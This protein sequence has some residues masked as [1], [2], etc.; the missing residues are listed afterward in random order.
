MFTA[1]FHKNQFLMLNFHN[2][3]TNANTNYQYNKQQF[4]GWSKICKKI[5]FGIRDWLF[6][7]MWWETKLF[8]KKKSILNYN[9]NEP[10]IHHMF[11]RKKQV[12]NLTAHDFLKLVLM[13]KYIKTYTIKNNLIAGLFDWSSLCESSKLY[14]WLFVKT[15]G[16]QQ[17][18]WF[19]K[20]WNSF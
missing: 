17:H 7:I 4:F 16:E 3:L 13:K 20:N 2:F 14:D 1:Y 11:S 18:N 10:T 15:Y 19:K 8:R 12:W 6:V 5:I 9:L